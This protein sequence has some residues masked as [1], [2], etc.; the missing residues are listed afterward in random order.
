MCLAV[1]PEKTNGHYQFDYLPFTGPV[2]F[3]LL[4]DETVEAYVHNQEKQ[5]IVYV[6][7]AS[8]CDFEKLLEDVRR[9]KEAE[10]PPER[11]MYKQDACGQWYFAGS[12]AERIPTAFV[13]YAWTAYLA[14]K[15]S[16]VSS[17]ETIVVLFSR[18]LPS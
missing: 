9:R 12:Y 14:A 5:G 17:P 2:Y 16:C 1:D 7:F 4:S 6:G 3:Q 11:A 8:L 15:A 18:H 13:G 10:R